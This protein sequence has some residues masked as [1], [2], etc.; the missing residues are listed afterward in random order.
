MKI[1]QYIR[2]YIKIIWRKFRIISRLRFEI[3]APEIYEMFGYNHAETI[4]YI[5][6][7]R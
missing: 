1:Y 3:Y 5:K 4:E 2:R 7:T 6:M